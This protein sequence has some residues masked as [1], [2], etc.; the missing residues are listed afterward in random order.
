MIAAENLAPTREETTEKDVNH[1]WARVELEKARVELSGLQARAAV[2]E[3]QLAQSRK[4]ARQLAADSVAQQDLLRTMKA[5]ED[6][7]LLYVRKREEARIGD[8]MDQR[9]ILNVIVAEQ[10][11]VPALPKHSGW[12]FGMVGFVLAGFVSTGAAFARDFL[13]PAFRTPDE[14]VSYLQTPVLASFPR[15]IA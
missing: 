3:A 11:V 15:D 12:V 14:V 10:P 13:D 9:G 7:Y 8:A 4:Q 5:A 6:N 1:E 2:A